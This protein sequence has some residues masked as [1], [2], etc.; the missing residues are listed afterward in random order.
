M[1]TQSEFCGFVPAVVVACLIVSS[2]VALKLACRAEHELCSS[3]KRASKQAQST[4]HKAE[5]LL[6]ANVVTVYS[7]LSDVFQT[8]VTTGEQNCRRMTE[9]GTVY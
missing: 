8:G 7:E 1:E 5:N 4:F 9:R 6:F 3:S 2:T